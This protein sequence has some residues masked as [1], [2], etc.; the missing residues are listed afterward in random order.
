MTNGEPRARLPGR[1]SG[2][3]S[4]LLTRLRVHGLLRKI[5]R[6]YRCHLT[7]FGKRVIALA[8]KLRETV[9]LPELE[10]IRAAA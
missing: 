6:G 2:Q 8:F 3:V 7:G 1:G 5:A 10:L 4:R 9:V